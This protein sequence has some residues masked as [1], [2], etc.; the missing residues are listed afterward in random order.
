MLRGLE[1]S[2]LQELLA[3]LREKRPVHPM[4]RFV[5]PA[6]PPEG[7]PHFVNLRVL[8]RMNYQLKPLPNSQIKRR[9]PDVSL[10]PAQVR[11][12]RDDLYVIRAE[13]PD[14]ALA[15][16]VEELQQ[17]RQRPIGGGFVDGEGKI[18]GDDTIA[19]L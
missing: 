18:S 4:P 13:P 6:E 1:R 9:K 19:R 15:M 8:P 7:H 11:I 3:Q 10:N 5:I 2:P 17:I 16:R 12:A 14:P